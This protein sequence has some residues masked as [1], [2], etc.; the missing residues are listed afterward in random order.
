[1]PTPFDALPPGV[2]WRTAK[3]TKP[4]QRAV[5]VAIA[6][7]GSV[8]IG[9]PTDPEAPV[10]KFTHAEWSTFCRGIVTGYFDDL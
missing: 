1:M 8:Y 5:A 7:D 3:P 2:K 4:G 10:L 6:P 9:D